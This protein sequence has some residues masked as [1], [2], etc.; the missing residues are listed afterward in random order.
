[1]VTDLIVQSG[2]RVTLK[3]LHGNHSQGRHARNC[4]N[5]ADR[6]NSFRRPESA[7]PCYRSLS[8]R[9]VASCAHRSLSSSRS[10]EKV[11]DTGK[12]IAFGDSQDRHTT[13]SCAEFRKPLHI[14][15][16]PS[17]Y[18]SVSEGE[19]KCSG[20]N[21]ATPVPANKSNSNFKA[22]VVLIRT[23]QSSS[24]KANDQNLVLG[25]QQESS[26]VIRSTSKAQMGLSIP[27]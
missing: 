11:I 19:E 4:V 21:R 3:V 1:M 8:I 6:R 7:V 10:F 20:N 14:H 9:P 18:H 27:H 26:S 24:E 5:M 17:G 23:Q 22:R 12:S 16:L 13:M 25:G 15:R 2:D